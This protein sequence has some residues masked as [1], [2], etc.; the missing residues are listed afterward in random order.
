MSDINDLLNIDEKGEYQNY[1]QNNP[2]RNFQRP[3][4]GW[5]KNY[6]SFRTMI[7]TGVLK[8]LYVIG[9]LINTF[10]GIGVFIVGMGNVYGDNDY[11]FLTGLGMLT[12]GNLVWRI[13]CE[14]LIL[15]FR[16]VN[17]ISNM[18]NEMLLINNNL[19]KNTSSFQNKQAASKPHIANNINKP[20]T[21]KEVF[22]GKCGTKM[23]NPNLKFCTNCGERL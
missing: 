13:L 23:D 1:S 18:E 20:N 21:P 9:L 7:T 11:Y 19:I 22:C 12:L 17:S 6:I 10:G 14:F 2:N 5:F 4:R 15:Q 16:M 3:T 8:V